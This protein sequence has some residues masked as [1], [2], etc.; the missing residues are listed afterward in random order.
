MTAQFV[1]FS[2]ERCFLGLDVTHVKEILRYQEMTPVPLARS[3]F[4]GLINLRGQIVTAMDL[5]RRLGLPPRP[6]GSRPMNLVVRSDDGSLSLLVDE[7]GDVLEVDEASFEKP[8]AT[9]QGEM[10]TLIKGT[11][12]VESGL[13]LELDLDLLVNGSPME[14]TGSI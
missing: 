1:T 2:V 11:Y 13:L 12:K 7:I 10:R 14:S 3:D 6:K 4:E 8:P 9:L 5:R